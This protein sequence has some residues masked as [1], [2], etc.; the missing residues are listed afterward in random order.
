[1]NGIEHTFPVSEEIS[2]KLDDVK[3]DLISNPAVAEVTRTVS[4]SQKTMNTIAIFAGLLAL[5]LWLRD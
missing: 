1:M 3:N 2:H 5:V 4:G